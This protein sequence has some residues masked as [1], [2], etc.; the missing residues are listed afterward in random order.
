MAGDKMSSLGGL[1]ALTTKV[2]VVRGHLVGACGYTALIREM[3]AWFE[4]GA[5]PADFPSGLQRDPKENASLLVVT[6][7]G[8]LLQYEHTAYPLVIESRQWAIG[9]GRDFAMAAMH[10]GRSA[11]Q[12]VQVACDLCN[13]C[14]GGVDSVRLS[15]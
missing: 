2:H 1:Y 4:R 15:K 8:Q 12:A 9:S 11:P 10:L 7:A 6:P 14:G 5:D 13:D 3:H